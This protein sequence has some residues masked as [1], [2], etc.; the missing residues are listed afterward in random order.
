MSIDRLLL[1][2]KTGIFPWYSEGEPILWWSPNPRL[3]LYPWEMKISRTLKKIIKKDSFQVSFDRAFEQVIRECARIRVEKDEGTWI[4]DEMK[5]AYVNMHAEGYAHSV[6]VWKDGR[7]AG[8]LYGI[9]LGR[10]F[11]GESMFSR[12][13]NASSVGLVVLV[14]FLMKMSFELLDCQV[15]TEHLRRFGAVEVSRR[16]FLRQLEKAV[17]RPTLRGKWEL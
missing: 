6:E 15:T 4:T 13:S 9:S 8:G 16:R 7:L 14:Q 17:S 11:F 5:N 10:A 2:Y 3:V 12:V 1:A